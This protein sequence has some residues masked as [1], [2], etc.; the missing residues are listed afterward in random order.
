MKRLI[1]LLS[2]V[3]ICAL[4]G[5]CWHIA[6]D[7]FNLSRTYT[8]LPKDS[9]R[10]LDQSVSA[11]LEQ[12]YTYL[13]RGHQCYAFGS[14]D[15]RYVIKLPR[16]DR[17]RLSFFL[18]ACPFSAIRPYREMIRTDI[19]KRQ[20][21]LL[22]SFR[23]AFEELKEETALLYLHLHKTDHFQHPL[24]MKDRVGR[25][26]RL[27]PNQTA[28]ILQEK[29]PIMMASF[30]DRL[31]AG[32][33]KGAEEIL[34][35]FLDVVSVRFQKGIYNKDP[36]FLRNFGWDKGKGI[37][38]DIGSFYRKPDQSFQEAREK[39]FQETIAHVRNWL[40]EVDKEMLYTF[41]Q[42]TERIKAS[43]AASDCTYPK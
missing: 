4:T 39:S 17:Y 34:D 32:D 16:Y 26:N 1:A 40:S 27:D 35:A 22:E 33:R 18:R 30:Q 2:L 13:G 28:F 5:K 31:Q 29:K 43:W 38:I 7:G 36:S 21:V 37:Q 25:T 15:G 9:S 8:S 3:G 23:L 12:P 19:E 24:V 20:K 11:L 14:E 41:D 42:K 10:P 6:K